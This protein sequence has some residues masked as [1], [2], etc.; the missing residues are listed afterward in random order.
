MKHLILSLLLVFSINLPAQAMDQG[1]QISDTLP[2]ISLNDQ[3][4][5][6]QD[7]N[8]IKGDNGATIVFVRSADW[9]PYCQ[10]QLKELNDFNEAFE[11]EGY[12]LTAISYDNIDKLQKFSVKNDI[13]FTLLS[14]ETSAVIKELGLLNEDYPEGHFA[15]GVP[16]PVIYII[17]SN[18]EIIG[19]YAEDG[20][21]NRPN[22]KDILEDIRR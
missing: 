6:A 16:H 15:H 21:K 18:N 17:N 5:K 22:P 4:N 20:Y 10:K 11:K 8:T 9:C 1:P 7:L 12:P 2:A 3:N 14:D 19:H 13:Q